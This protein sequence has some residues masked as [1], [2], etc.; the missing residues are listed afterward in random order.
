MKKLIVAA[1]AVLVTV[2]LGSCSSGSKKASAGG[3]A[4]AKVPSVPTASTVGAGEGGLNIIAWAGYHPEHGR[5]W[6]RRPELLP[7]AAA[8][9][10]SGACA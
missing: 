7:R 8:A 3:T 4:G 5:R 1:T 10:T 6:R 9:R 2:T